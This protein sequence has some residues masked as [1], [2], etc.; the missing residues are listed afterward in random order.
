M[1]QDRFLRVNENLIVAIDTI[2]R[3]ES[4]C[5]DEDNPTVCVHFPHG[6]EDY[7]GD[8]AQAFLDLAGT[9]AQRTAKKK[10]HAHAK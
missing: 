8:E 9:V 5:C 1:S 4:K 2:Q 6:C 7:T 3:I 10:T